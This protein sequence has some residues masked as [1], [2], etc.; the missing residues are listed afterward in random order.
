MKTT[1]KI[2]LSVFVI[3]MLFILTI[4]IV[5]KVKISRGVDTSNSKVIEQQ[6]S[7][8]KF[9]KIDV[10]DG[11]RII[12]T[13]DSTK[14]LKI[15]GDSALLSFIKM[16]VKNGT[17]HI[18]LTKYLMKQ[19]KIEV[20]I[21]N[22]SLNE[23]RLCKDCDFTNNKMMNVNSFKLSCLLNS[24]ANI[25]G[26]FGSVNL[27]MTLETAVNLKGNCKEL[28][29]TGSGAKLNADEFIVKKC[30]LNVNLGCISSVNVTDELTVTAGLGSIITYSGNPVI[31]SVN[32]TG[33]AQLMKKEEK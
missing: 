15:K 7:I 6:H 11:F 25:N 29:Y 5:L 12:Y 23:V 16:E 21:T 31:K 19:K 24:S 33:G 9:N 2:L 18:D 13:Q 1:N 30:N 27:F 22:D 3:I 20:Y 8:G 26:N 28:E 10:N 17:L 32:I 14:S 4:L